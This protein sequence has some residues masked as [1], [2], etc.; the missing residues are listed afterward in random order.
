MTEKSLTMR[1]FG[2]A[3]KSKMS[4]TAKKK[5]F[6]ADK[7]DFESR[8]EAL[9]RDASKQEVLYELYLNH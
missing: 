7:N 1:S 3:I 8:P 5:L 6:D 4:K 2:D 9:E